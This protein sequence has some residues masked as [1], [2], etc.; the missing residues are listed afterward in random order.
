MTIQT[1]IGFT[2][3]N[4]IMVLPPNKAIGTITMDWYDNDLT[5]NN[6]RT[7]DAME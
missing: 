4:K 1:N 5:N 2:T 7:M 3:P 6:D